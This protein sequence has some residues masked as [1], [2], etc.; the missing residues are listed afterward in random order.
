MK[1]LNVMQ[2]SEETNARIKRLA[3]DKDIKEERLIS[4][5]ISLKENQ[6]F[7]KE[8]DVILLDYLEIQVNMLNVG[9]INKLDGE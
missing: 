9:A 1:G 5:F 8:Q 2:M 6:M 3:E 4:A 7:S